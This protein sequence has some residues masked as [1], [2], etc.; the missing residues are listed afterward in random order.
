MKKGISRK[1][2]HIAFVVWLNLSPAGY[3]VTESLSFYDQCRWLTLLRTANEH[4]LGEI[5]V[6]ASRGILKRLD[7][8]FQAF[9]RRVQVGEAPGLPRFR[10]SSR[11]VTIDVVCPHNGMV[12]LHNGYYLIRGQGFPRL[13]AY[14]APP[15]PL[16]TLLK[17]VRLTGRRCRREAS[18]VC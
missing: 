2:A 11:C 15:L 12:R 13:R 10:P 14:S 7:N 3:G 1:I 9:F 8:A 16:E 6:A 5:S 18:P 17:A 4:G